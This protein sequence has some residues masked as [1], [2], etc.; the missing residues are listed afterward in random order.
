[1]IDLNFLI[2]SHDLHQVIV[3]APDIRS[4][5]L[6]TKLPQLFDRFYRKV[7]HYIEC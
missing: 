6:T 3:F 4:D 5:T 2:Y 7:F 1:M